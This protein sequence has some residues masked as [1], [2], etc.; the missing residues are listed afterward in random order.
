MN[1]KTLWQD[2]LCRCD[3]LAVMLMRFLLLML[4]PAVLTAQVVRN[5]VPVSDL[6]RGR[7]YHLEVGF[8]EPQAPKAAVPLGDFTL[9]CAVRWKAGAEDQV[10]VNASEEPASS[11][12]LVLTG[13]R[14][15]KF[16]MKTAAGK[17]EILSGQILPEEYWNLH[18]VVSVKRDPRQAV[19]GIW[20]DGVEVASAAVPPG[21]LHLRNPMPP[22]SPK[23]T[24]EILIRRVDL[25]DRALTR[26]EI[27]DWYL[28]GRS[29]MTMLPNTCTFLGGTDA[30]SLIE[31]GSFEAWATSYDV[32]AKRPA[33]DS[34]GG[35]RFQMRS[36]A[37]ETDTVFRQDRPLN[38]G[39]LEQQLRRSEAQMVMLVFGRQECLER[40][41]E[42]LPAFRVALA[43]LVARCQKHVGVVALAGSVPFETKQ[44]PLPD[45]VRRN[46]VLKKYQEAM[47][48]IAKASKI[49]FF[50]VFAVWPNDAKDFTTDGVQL[51]ARGSRLYGEVLYR[52]LFKATSST[53]PEA[54][55]SRVADK[56]RPLIQAKNKLWHEYW[57]PSNWAFL[58]GDRTAQPSSRDHLNPQVRWFPKE[59][60]KYQGMIRE[61][62]EAIWKLAEEQGRKVP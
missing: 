43:D 51:S 52:Q 59:L 45:S 23:D 37:W 17:T 42:G 15:V 20:V 8:A 14:R 5:A 47:S 46:A 48:E 60:E 56:L 18:V 1:R 9:A 4:L 61:K 12:R 10:I 33:G 44:A 53:P 49:Q 28:E 40:G 29:L 2:S 32:M 54:E 41:D 36:L 57:R 3:S 35:G 21:V 24:D 16:E 19:S 25:Y 30:V 7:V 11:C 27:I 62:E 50:D 55:V 22:R 39:S 34:Q 13:D 31:E 26:G 6:E 58:Y 38:F